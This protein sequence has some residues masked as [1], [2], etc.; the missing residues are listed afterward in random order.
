MKAYGDLNKTLAE[1]IAVSNIHGERD[2]AVN[3]I[4]IQYV[5]VYISVASYCEIQE[6]R[7]Y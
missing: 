2:I 1:H 3:L 5:K 4:N 7:L 6:S